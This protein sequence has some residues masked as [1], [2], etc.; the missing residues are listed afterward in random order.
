ML[1]DDACGVVIPAEAVTRLSRRLKVEH[2]TLI[3][4]RMVQQLTSQARTWSDLQRT[5]QVVHG[6][7]PLTNVGA[8][9]IG[10][11]EMVEQKYPPVAAN[12]CPARKPAQARAAPRA[13]T[14]RSCVVSLE[15][16]Y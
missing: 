13:T 15:F 11:R 9:Q 14:A 1:P 6:V 8:S 10:S 16:T 7:D 2:A 12:I 3:D 5:L 4:A